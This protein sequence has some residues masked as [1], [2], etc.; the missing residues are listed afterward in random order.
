MSEPFFEPFPPQHPVEDEP[1]VIPAI[2]WEPP[3]N[4]T[5]AVV[6]LER[7]I[8]RTPDTLVWL[9]AA[10]VYPQGVDIRLR[11]WV[12]PESVATAV[13]W[14]ALS[15]EAL[16]IGLRLADGT[17]L[18]A[19]LDAEPRPLVAF[20]EVPDGSAPADVET[21]SSSDTPAPRVMM[22][23]TVTG[24][25]LSEIAQAWVWPVPEGDAIDL[26]IA[27]E[28][29]GIPE[30]STPVA[31]GPLRDAMSRCQALWPLP[32]MPDLPEGPFGWTAYAPLA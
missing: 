14:E 5:P 17:K 32:E 20:D 29:R 1:Q 9:E 24:T 6:P 23:S 31:L 12:S 25:E 22:S 3:R 19:R 26:V 10:H 27:W 21:S 11:A 8:A 15:R 28:S 16:R 4:V 30:T 18:G 13:S 7:E 2:P